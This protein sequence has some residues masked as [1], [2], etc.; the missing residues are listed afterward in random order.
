MGRPSPLGIEGTGLS[1]R[2]PDE[3]GRPT[4][5]M[6]RARDERGAWQAKRF[7]GVSWRKD[8]T[9]ILPETAKDW[10]RETRKTFIKGQAVASAATFQE[11]AGLLVENLAAAGVSDGRQALIRAVSAGLQAEGITDMRT[12]AFPSRVRSWLTGLRVGWSLAEGAKNRRTTAG[13]LSAATRNKVLIVCR[14]VTGL[15]VS[16]RRLAFDPLAELPKFKQPDTIKPLFT[17]DELRRM[18]S[19]EARAHAMREQMDIEQAITKHGG[20]RTAAVQA[21]AESRARLGTVGRLVIRESGTEPMIRVMAESDDEGL[22]SAVVNDIT[23][24]IRDVA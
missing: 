4:V 21:I 11:H 20:T 17:V 14:Q 1:F 24:A 16:K 18:V 8:G 7:A 5:A 15:A 9:P 2:D 13:L 19:D 12:D 3:R 10:A 23:K 6:V 22:V